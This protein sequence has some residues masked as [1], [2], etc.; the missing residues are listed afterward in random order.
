MY[1]DSVKLCS[2]SVDK[3]VV[4]TISE[5]LEMG[6][7]IESECIAHDLPSQPIDCSFHPNKSLIAYI[8]GSTFHIYDL[9]VS[10]L[11]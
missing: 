9:N 5:T 7:V 3:I 8:V 2:C 6:R 10:S 11:F 1:F 4:W